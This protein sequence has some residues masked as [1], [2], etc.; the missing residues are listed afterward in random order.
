MFNNTVHLLAEALEK[1]DVLFRIYF[2]KVKISINSNLFEYPVIQEYKSQNELKV[3]ISDVVKAINA[4]AIEGNDSLKDISEEKIQIVK[5]ILVKGDFEQKLLFYTNSTSNVLESCNWQ[6]I[7][8]QTK[9]MGTKQ[10]KG[11]LL[12]FQYSDNTK[13]DSEENIV[14]ELTKDQVE[15]LINDLKNLLQII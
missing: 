15:D 7:T 11:A 9:N 8:R 13:E 14:L 12:N 4:I 3:Y 6:I 2:N 1:G 5:D 10:V